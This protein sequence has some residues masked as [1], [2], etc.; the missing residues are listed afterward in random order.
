MR[1]GFVGR[2]PL[3]GQV[4]CLVALAASATVAAGCGSTHTSSAPATSAGQ[5]AQQAAPTPAKAGS[6]A[7]GAPVDVWA[8]APLNN[9][10]GS[11]PQAPAGANVAA[12]YI[13]SHGGLG[14]AHHRLIVK[15]CNTQGTPQ[16]EVQ[17]AQQAVADSRAIA[18]VDPIGIYNADALTQVLQQGKLPAVNPYIA[19]YA[20]LRNPIN[21]PLYSPNFASTACALLGHRAAGIK[22]VAFAQINL[23]LSVQSDQQAA[24][25]AQ[26]AGLTVTGN[27]TFP[28]TVSDLSPYI[29][30]L[31]AHNPQMVVLSM[32]PTLVGQFVQ[33]ATQLGAQW[34]YCAQDGIVYW[35]QLVGLGS[36]VSNFYLASVLPEVVQP[37]SNPIVQA[38]RAQ[39]AA[40]V[41]AGDKQASLSPVADPL[42]TFQSWLSNQVVVQVTHKMKGAITRQKFFAALKKATVTFPGVLPPVDFARRNPMPAYSRLFNTTMF[43]KKW[44]PATKTEKVV[45]GVPPTAMENLVK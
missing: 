42:P 37:S 6:P 8:I 25:A 19:T 28:V 9:P 4:A 31:Q 11:V 24:Q 18:A 7:T 34:T 33:A 38:F 14:V 35:Q 26:R 17:C 44:D 3:R 21:F 22:R 23:P 30:Q 43:L 41:Q 12:R 39:A 27:V 10:I 15:T 36:A 32:Q 5:A 40:E 45:S 29:R 13:N 20:Q 16:G 2:P 1:R